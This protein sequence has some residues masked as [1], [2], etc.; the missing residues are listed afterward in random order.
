MLVQGL[1][2]KAAGTLVTGLV[3][4]TAYET[5]RKAVGKTRV[6]NWCLLSGFKCAYVCLNKLVL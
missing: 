2:A 4:V 5:L 3:G 1:L 6:S